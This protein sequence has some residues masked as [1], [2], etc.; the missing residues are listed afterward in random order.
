MSTEKEKKAQELADLKQELKGLKLSLSIVGEYAQS[1]RPLAEK[2]DAIL[3]KISQL[4]AD[5]QQ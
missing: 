5:L 4:E 3:E 2:R 1:S